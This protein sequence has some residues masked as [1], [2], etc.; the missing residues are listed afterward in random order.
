MNFVTKNHLIRH[1][2]QAPPHNYA[3]NFPTIPIIVVGV[4]ATSLLLMAYY[5]FVIKCCL[6]RNTIDLIIER[7]LSFSRQHENQSSSIS[8]ASEPRGLDQEVINSIPT[9]HYKIEKENGERVSSECAFCLSEFQQDE[10]LRVIPNC[11][12]LFHIDCVDIWLQNNANCPLCRSKVSLTREIQV[13]HVLT[14]RPSPYLQSQN[15]ENIIS[16]CEDFVVID[17]DNNEHVDEGQ[18]LHEIRQERGKELEVPRDS[19]S[20]LNKKAIKLQK[21][22]SMGDECI[23]GMKDKFDGIL[24]QPI[25]RSFSMDLSIEVCG[26]SSIRAKRSFFSFGH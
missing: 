23:I 25:R 15:V 20:P 6:N 1:V 24:I 16:G 10:K 5:T 2:S 21:V 7:N 19:I 12:H 22:I 8:I 26:D 13:E 11:N 4:M 3:T 14:P 18:N 9:I 17:L